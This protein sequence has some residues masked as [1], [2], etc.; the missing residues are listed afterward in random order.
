MMHRKNALFVTTSFPGPASPSAGIF[1]GRL[2]LAISES[3]PVEVVVPAGGDRN[4]TLGDV[5]VSRLRYAPR[6]MER[7][8]QGPGGIPPALA[9]APYLWTVVPIMLLRMLLACLVRA[10]RARV[11]HAHWAISAVVAV[12]ASRVWRVP[13]VTTCRGEDINRAARSHVSRL[14]L[15]IAC[16]VSARV[17]CV[18][19]ALASRLK[20]MLPWAAARVRVICNGVG[21]EFLAVPLSEF[22]GNQLKVLA[23]GSLIPRKDFLTLVQAAATVSRPCSVHIVG[24]GS[25]RERIAAAIRDARIEDRVTVGKAVEPGTM[26]ALLAAHDVL[27]LS[28]LAEGR[29]NVVVE[30]MAAGRVVIATDL[31]GMRELITPHVNG[32]LFPVGDAATLAAHLDALAADRPLCRRMAA[33]ARASVQ[34]E[35][36]TWSAAAADYLAVYDELWRD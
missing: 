11:I 6:W 10:R 2:A 3:I 4:S 29:P 21:E 18:N 28:S 26:P 8:L 32:L 19:E 16:R 12:P 22:G 17:V 33:A 34:A 36:L 31:P 1:V 13:L 35:G 23:V 30:A 20:S 15:G 5:Q 27:V 14:L 24:E 25:E 7:L 9:R